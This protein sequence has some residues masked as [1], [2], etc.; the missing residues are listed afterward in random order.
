VK[1]TEEQR[2]M[3]DIDR[4]LAKR[5]NKR[6]EIIRRMRFLVTIL[7]VVALVLHLSLGCCMH[8]AHGDSRP[9]SVPNEC[10]GHCH[11][12]GPQ[13]ADHAEEGSD[14]PADC[15]AEDCDEPNCSFIAAAQTVAP[16][17][18]VSISAAMLPLALSAT[19]L[20]AE[21]GYQAERDLAHDAALPVR[22][23]LWL[24]IILI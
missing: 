24:Q 1:Y 4:L 22:A 15:P 17:P 11:H 14:L 9:A 16:E 21:L 12:H 19:G 10:A 5:N 7:T 18:L 23:H 3:V 20:P 13:A 8:H 2:L 6:T